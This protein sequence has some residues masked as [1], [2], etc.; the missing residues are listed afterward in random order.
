MAPNDWSKLKSPS[1]GTKGLTEQ[2][3]DYIESLIEAEQLKPNDRVPSETELAKMF[4]VSKGTVGE[5]L[6]LLEHMGLVTRKVGSGTYISQMPRSTLSDSIGRFLMVKSCTDEDLMWFREILEPEIAALAARNAATKDLNK[7]KKIVEQIENPDPSFT[8]EDLA[9]IDTRFHI[10]LAESTGN[11]LVAAIIH[12]IKNQ[13]AE[14][15]PR[16]HN[17]MQIEERFHSHR[18]VYEAVTARAPELAN[19]K[20]RQHMSVALNTVRKVQSKNNS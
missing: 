12:G 10:A 19:E 3:A 13:I 1:I 7:L 17:E 11:E 8:D 14:T 6:A 15:W 16:Y 2:V 9:E 18:Q 4:G 20:M 5:A